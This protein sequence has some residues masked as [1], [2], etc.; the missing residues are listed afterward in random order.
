MEKYAMKLL[1]ELQAINEQKNIAKG[2]IVLESITTYMKKITDDF[3]SGHPFQNADLPKDKI[4]AVFA[5]LWLL[6]QKDFREAHDDFGDFTPEGFSEN[7]LLFMQNLGEKADKVF[8]KTPEVYGQESKKE[9]SAEELLLYIGKEKSSTKYKEW[10]QK[11]DEAEIQDE[12]LEQVRNAWKKIEAWW[13][14]KFLSAQK[15]KEQQATQSQ[16]EKS[17]NDTSQQTQHRTGATKTNNPAA[18]QMQNPQNT[19]TPISSQA[20]V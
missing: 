8:S 1:A 17:A 10:R 13:N 9:L 6:G 19:N 11:M 18:Q 2:M 12:V 7:F 15:M 3:N 16:Q 5:G 4:A 20:A 14:N